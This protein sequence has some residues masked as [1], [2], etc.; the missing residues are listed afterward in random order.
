MN[1]EKILKVFSLFLTGGVGLFSV[2]SYGTPLLDANDFLPVLQV[3]VE[4][5]A[6]LLA[7]K[8]PTAVEHGTDPLLERPIVRAATTQDAINVIVAEHKQGCQ[9]IA[10]PDGGYGF[11]ATGIGTYRK[12]MENVSAARVAQR[13]AYVE[14]FMQAKGQMAS[15]VGEIAVQ[16]VSNFDKKTE[17][18]DTDIKSLRNQAKEIT[19]TQK[20]IVSKVLKGYV[21]YGVHDDFEK[22]I[23]YVSIVSTPRT[24]GQYSR[25]AADTLMSESL[26]DGLNAILAEIQNG[27]VPPVG[28]RI[29]DVP[30]TGEVAFV[31]FGSSVVR[32]DPDP[33]LQVDL[34]LTAEK[35]AGLRASD[36][37]CGIITGDTVTSA[38]HLDEFT[39]QTV[40]DFEAIEK[41]DPATGLI[42]RE[43]IAHAD[44]RRKEF[45]NNQ[46]FHQTIESARRGVLPPGVVRRIW[47]DEDEAFAYAVAVYVP[48]VSSAATVAIREMDNAQII[49]PI[50]PEK[51][52]PTVP[53]APA[54]LKPSVSGTVEQKL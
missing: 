17:T 8:E 20:A 28:G 21:T 46:E 50:K 13:N 25:L 4:Q 31:G 34:V 24:R 10:M 53:H 40:S 18:L 47:L 19:E 9:M 6:A 52:K 3:S 30:A 29:V 32:Q 12:D 41:K 33:S 36:A 44:G 23:V 14:A 38:A 54:P 43:D 26:N 49:K 39:K 51:N 16:G 7:V 45:R 35:I 2:P 11:V 22:G 27:L 42:S 15:L 5:R 48:S 37:L 1:R